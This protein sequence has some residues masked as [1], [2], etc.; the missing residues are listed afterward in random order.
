M[1]NTCLSGVIRGSGIAKKRSSVEMGSTSMLG[2][3]SNYGR[4]FKVAVSGP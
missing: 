2:A 4:A 3:I 1:R